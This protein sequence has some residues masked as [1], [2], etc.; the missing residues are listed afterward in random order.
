MRTRGCSIESKISLDRRSRLWPAIDTPP[1]SDPEIFHAALA[2]YDIRAID[3]TAA[4]RWR[5]FFATSA[6]RDRA[7]SALSASLPTL[8]LNA[9]DVADEDWAARSQA[10]LR[11]I[12]VGTIVVAPPWDVP[13]DPQNAMAGLQN[14][15]RPTL[16]VV[17]EPSMGFGTGHHATT[18]LCLDAL[19]H[20][21]VSGRTVLDVGTGSGILAITASLLGAAE[22][23]GIDDDQD[24]VH[25]ARDNLALN[26]GAIVSL[27]VGDV[28][29][30]ALAEADIV[31]ANL[32]G[33][34]LIAAADPLQ[35]LSKRGGR[36]ILSGFLPHEESEVLGRY[37]G[38]SVERRSEAE[39]WV[40]VT[41]HIESGS[42][43]KAHPRAPTATRAA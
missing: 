8:S 42:S 5:V 39:G 7:A 41:L 31:L 25:S 32:T 30:L 13:A 26:G 43:Q 16:V 34:T 37:A 21:D 29:S 11:A 19:Q 4:D 10:S 12:Q 38:V 23:T 22:V 18:R 6:E 40:C 17:I 3:D 20:V 15:T 35:R 9:V 24:A 28:R 1:P 14:K 33:G 27:L 36:L 2:D